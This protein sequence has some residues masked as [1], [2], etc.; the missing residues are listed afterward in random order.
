M[1]N[2]AK[3]SIEAKGNKASFIGVDQRHWK[4]EFWEKGQKLIGR[5]KINILLN[6]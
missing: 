4:K 6:V 2:K 5:D 1:I 3:K